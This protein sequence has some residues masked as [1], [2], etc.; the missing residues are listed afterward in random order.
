MAFT[1]FTDLFSKI[2]QTTQTYVTDMSTGAIAAV[3][4]VVTVGLTLMFMA[5]AFLII[6]GGVQMPMSE[7]LG[8]SVRVALVCAAALGSGL[9]QGQ[10]AEA[11]RTTPDALATALIS[12][13]SGK[14]AQ[15]ATLIDTAGEQGFT[16]AGEAWA[17]M[18]AMDIGQSL[19][20]AFYGAIII[21]AT[22]IF[23]AIG[24]AFLLL[25]KLGLSILAGLG[26]MFIAGL[27]WQPTHRFFEVWVGQVVNMI[28]LVVMLAASFGL[29]LTIFT[30][31][32][33]G[34][35]MDP[36]QNKAY[37]MGG[38]L[39]LSVAMLVALLQLPGIAAA[40]AGGASIAFLYEMRAVGGG[41]RAAGRAAQGV[42]KAVHSAGAASVKGVAAVG[43]SVGQTAGHFRGKKAA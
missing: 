9:Y 13:D 16:K 5:Y 26:P 2:D 29:M 1:L 33:E 37:A 28:L 7:F 30:G 19:V 10:I 18:S 11:I 39:M 34:L 35:A 4:P 43:R 27:L 20:F 41:A 23:V 17:E 15:A 31:Y 32:V 6:R 42:S 38:L 40:L 8:K 25:A 14:G 24:G 12:D 36:E 3:T 22:I 21:L